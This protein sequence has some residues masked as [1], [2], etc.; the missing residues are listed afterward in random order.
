MPDET[1]TVVDL[2]GGDVLADAECP[3]CGEPYDWIEWDTGHG[4]SRCGIGYSHCPNDGCD[5]S[6]RTYF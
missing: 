6:I 1:V 4:C 2:A 3:C 5:G